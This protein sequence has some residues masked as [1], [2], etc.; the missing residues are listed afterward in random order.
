MSSPMALL[1]LATLQTSRA[2]DYTGDGVDDLVVGVPYEADISGVLQPGAIEVIRGSTSGLTTAGDAFIHQN[3]AGVTGSNEANEYF[4]NAIGAGDVDGDGTDDLIVG[5]PAELARG[6]HCGSVFRLELA[7]TRSSLSVT[8]SQAYSQDSTGISDSAELGD[9]FGQAIA[10]ADFDNDGYDDVVVGIPG[11]DV[12]TIANAG[13][14][15]YL[16]GSASGLTTSGQLF[17]HQDSSGM[18]GTAEADDLFG[19][20]LA[21]GDFDADGF[22]DLAIAVPTEDWSGTNEGSVHVMYGSSIGPGVTSPNDEL[23]SAGEGSAAG[24]SDDENLCGSAVA[25]GDFDSDGYADLAIGCPGYDV[26]TATQAGAV[27]IVY[28]SASGLDDSELWSQDSSGVTG[29]AEDDDRFGLELTSGDYDGDGYADLAISAPTES[30]S[31][32][33]QNGVVHVLMGSSTGITDS[34]DV[35]LAQ[36]TGILVGGSP[37]DY[38]DWGSALTSG[39]YD[40]DGRDDLAVGSPY[41]MDGGATRAGVV[42]V[43]YGSASGPSTTGDQLF[44]QNVVNID[45]TSESSDWF[46]YSLR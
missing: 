7:T 25:V 5:A 42:N 16:P 26:G 41:D 3:T 2:A 24:T 12:G 18:T 11:E 43:F 17:Y 40:D 15:E 19:W 13:A 1:A 22:A 37:A 31:G 33:V 32:F 44:H 27:L 38:E 28:G 10:V 20:E 30:Y 14:V 8:S 23:W 35:L 4:G 21:A 39:D 6:V 34:G 36:D 45:D 9:I 46:G 29:S